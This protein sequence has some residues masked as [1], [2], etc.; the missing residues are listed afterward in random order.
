MEKLIHCIQIKQHKPIN[1]WIISEAQLKIF[2]QKAQLSTDIAGD[3]KKLTGKDINL[4]D[5]YSDY[6]IFKNISEKQKEK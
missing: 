6:Y 3:I 1:S 5:D 2:L 4:T